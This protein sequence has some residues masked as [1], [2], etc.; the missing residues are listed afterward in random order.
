MSSR[1][2]YGA[3]I[4]GAACWGLI[5]LFIAP[6]Y[7][8]GFTPWDVVTIRVVCTFVLLI[9]IMFVFY[10]EQLKAQWKDH[11]FFAS[12]GIISIVFFLIISILK[13]FLNRVYR[14]PLRCF[15]QGRYLLRFYRVSF[16]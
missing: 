12:A 4:I 10:R 6:L 8:V 15:T 1:Y 11:F 3:T 14:L 9:G 16:F 13:C 7:E 2:I 5:G